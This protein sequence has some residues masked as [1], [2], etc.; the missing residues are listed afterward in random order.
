VSEDVTHPRHFAPL[1]FWISR[2]Q[3]PGYV[4]H[5]LANR[6]EAV[7]HCLEGS[8]VAKELVVI[9]LVQGVC[10]LPACSRMASR[11]RRGSRDMDEALLDVGPGSATQTGSCDEIDPSAEQ[12][13]Q[14]EL[15]IHVSGKARISDELDQRIDV[16]PGSS[17]VARQ[18]Q[19][20]S[21]C[22]ARTSAS[23]LPRCLAGYAALRRV[24]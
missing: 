14:P 11:W 4:L 24:P 8:A 22:P 1:D 21:E 2:L 7:S 6:E 16:A 5:G 12:L 23:A 13:F 17:F 15:E 19:K 3:L 10:D 20:V 9:H 18:S